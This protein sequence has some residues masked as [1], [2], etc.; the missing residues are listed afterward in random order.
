MKFKLDKKY[1]EITRIKNFNTDKLN[2]IGEFIDMLGHYSSIEHL[3]LIKHYLSENLKN[4]K[5]RPDKCIC[6]YYL[7]VCYGSIIDHGRN[8]FVN[9]WNWNNSNIDN[10]ILNLRH[11]KL[12][13]NVEELP[14][15]RYCQILTNLAN[16]FDFTGRYIESFKYWNRV[17]SIDPEFG[18]AVA[19][20]GDSLVYHGFNTMM[21]EQSQRLFIQV[22]Y[23]H[24]KRAEKL[25][26]DPNAL[27][28]YNEKLK[29]LEREYF[30]IINTPI[31]IEEPPIYETKYLNDYMNWCI[32]KRLLLNPYL[33]ID[34]YKFAIGDN[35]FIENSSNE[36]RLLFEQIKTEFRHAREL[37]FKS[38][39]DFNSNEIEQNEN[40]K[41]AFRVSYSL[42][43]KIAYLLNDILNLGIP[44][45]QV[46]FRKLWFTKGIREKGIKD[47]LSNKS[48]LLLRG[49]FWISKD[50]FLE[51]DKLSDIIEPDAK[52]LDKIRNY[53]EH[54]SFVIDTPKSES[55]F[56]YEIN[57]DEFQAKTLKLVAMIRETIM[58][59]P[60]TVYR[61]SAPV[62]PK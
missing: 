39:G 1:S 13:F 56:S 28:R 3:N 15:F 14:I 60:Y 50:L 43:D 17:I 46:S 47:S 41:I 36:S 22:G 23:K 32:N 19:N 2:L 44:F 61:E 24:L 55:K 7:A 9:A 5:K 27:P 11:A 35:I 25:L 58:Y 16:I 8:D 29:T 48:N 33:E 54:K 42:F 59:I 38:S 12:L 57:K 21:F 26:V 4:F 6:H 10:E 62:K 37:L 34:T 20:K 52:E 45:H 40:L 30:D 18:M 53:L 49:I 51:D 31:K